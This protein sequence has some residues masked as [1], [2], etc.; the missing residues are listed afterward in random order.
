[1]SERELMLGFYEYGNIYTLII[2]FTEFNAAY[3][4]LSPFVFC[5]MS[6]LSTFF[7]STFLMML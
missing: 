5:A 6:V 1:M 4:G 7:G 2:F 3:L